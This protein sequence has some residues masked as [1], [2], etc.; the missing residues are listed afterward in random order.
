[1]GFFDSL[2]KA[3]A[4]AVNTAGDMYNNSLLETWNAYKRKNSDELD[5]IIRTPETHAHKRAIALAAC[6]CNGYWGVTS[7]LNAYYESCPGGKYD[8]EPDVKRT[9]SNLIGKFSDMSDAEELTKS[10]RGALNQYF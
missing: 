8:N 7:A 3:A 4:A 5:R 1:M 9:I 2:V 10:L 6:Y